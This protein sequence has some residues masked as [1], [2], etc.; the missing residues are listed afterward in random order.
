MFVEFDIE[1]KNIIQQS[2][3]RILRLQSQQSGIGFGIF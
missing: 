3:S 2:N 1:F